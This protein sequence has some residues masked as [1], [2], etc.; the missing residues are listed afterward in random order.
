M[1]D[2]YCRLLYSKIDSKIMDP[3]FLSYPLSNVRLI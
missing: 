1:Y 2:P 3:L